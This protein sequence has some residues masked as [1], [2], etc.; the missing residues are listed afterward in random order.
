MGIPDLLHTGL[1][2]AHTG[3]FVAGGADVLDIGS[4]VNV[5]TG[6]GELQNAGGDGAQKG[7]IVRNEQQ[8]T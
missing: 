4:A 1:V 2:F 6:G 5:R 8:R 7:A 3:G